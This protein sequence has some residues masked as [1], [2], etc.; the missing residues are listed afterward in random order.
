MQGETIIKRRVHWTYFYEV[1]RTSAHITLDPRG[2]L[3]G[4]VQRGAFCPLDGI[5]DAPS[6][7]V[8]M[9]QTVVSMLGIVSL[10]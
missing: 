6:I 4:D 5:S 9:R 1:P 2:I 7:D 10:A 8:E 3:D